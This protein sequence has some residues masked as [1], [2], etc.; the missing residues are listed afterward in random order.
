MTKAKLDTWS[1]DNHVEAYIRYVN[2]NNEQDCFGVGVEILPKTFEV[3]YNSWRCRLLLSFW[4]IALWFDLPRMKMLHKFYEA[5]K[6]SE[7]V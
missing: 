6:L 1:S 5:K 2:K 7:K 3:S 4:I